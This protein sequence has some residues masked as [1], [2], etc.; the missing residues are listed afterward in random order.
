MN[1]ELIYIRKLYQSF[2]I[3]CC[4]QQPILD[5]EKNCLK[6]SIHQCT[7]TLMCNAVAKLAVSLDLVFICMI[8][9][10]NVFIIFYKTMTT[11]HSNF[12]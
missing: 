11:F 6:C 4:L 9:S 5:G 1:S 8:L 12:K 2:W 7:A 10:K 3:K